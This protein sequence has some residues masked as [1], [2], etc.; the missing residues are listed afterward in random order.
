MARV[1]LL[2]YRTL[3][4]GRGLDGQHPIAFS[5]PQAWLTQWLECT[6]AGCD[7]AR[8]AGF[9]DEYTYDDALECAA[10]AKADG[11]FR[12]DSRFGA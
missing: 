7:M 3:P 11:V 6:Y 2:T 8:I 4:G 9:L 5:V 12:Y 1:T 10:Q